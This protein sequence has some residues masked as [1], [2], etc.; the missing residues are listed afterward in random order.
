MDLVM[1]LI[2][3]RGNESVRRLQ[4]LTMDEDGM[5]KSITLFLEPANVCNTRFLTVEKEGRSDDQWIYLPALRKTRRIAAADQDVS[6]MGSDFSYSDMSIPDVNDY[7]YRI[8]REEVYD[9]TLC[10]VVESK[11]QEGSDSPYE[12]MVNWVDKDKYLPLKVEYYQRGSDE[13][14]K[15]LTIENPRYIDGHW[16]PESSV[17]HTLES[18]HRTVVTIRQ[19]KYDIPINSGY[20]TTNFLQTGR[21]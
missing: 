3:R 2:D 12:R 6:F 7:S 16:T 19:V 17:M 9:G 18:G 20:F 8:I 21:P 1:T 11:P 4:T 15:E 13:P 10:W 14:A 5:T